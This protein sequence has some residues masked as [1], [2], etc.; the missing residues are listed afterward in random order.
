[1][2][3]WARLKRVH[4]LR[5]QAHWG[6]KADTS[7]WPQTEAEQRQTDHGAPWDTNVIMAEW[8]LVLAKR[9]KKEGL[10]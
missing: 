9:L 10:L 2:R 6:N 7:K 4:E 1:M 8:H 3:D 5:M